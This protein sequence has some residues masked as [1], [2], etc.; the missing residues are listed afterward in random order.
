MELWELEAREVI[1]ST[2]N[3]YAHCADS[4]R[5]DDLVN[6]FA[7]DGVM[8]IVGRDPIVGRDAIRVFLTGTK[9]SLAATTTRPLIRHHVASIDIAVQDR[10]HATAR[11]YFFVITERGP[12]H[13]GRYR[14]E[15]VRTDA[16]WL[17]QRRRV[18]LEGRAESVSSDQ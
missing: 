2:I 1:R 17:F 18:Q 7:T 16:L 10:E 15:L 8:E 9:A 14:D 3:R 13:R 12:D 6:L 4:G 5:F 11:S